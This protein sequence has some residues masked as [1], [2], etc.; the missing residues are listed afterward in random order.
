MPK[1]DRKRLTER[2]SDGPYRQ[3]QRRQP[4]S[5]LYHHPR[6]ADDWDMADRVPFLGVSLAPPMSRAE[7]RDITVDALRGRDL[8]PEYFTAAPSLLMGKARFEKLNNLCYTTSEAVLLFM[9]TETEYPRD[10]EVIKCIRNWISHVEYEYGW[11]ERVSPISLQAYG[12]NTL[13]LFDYSAPGTCF[14]MVLPLDNLVAIREELGICV[15]CGLFKPGHSPRECAVPSW[16]SMKWWNAA[17]GTRTIRL[18][19]SSIPQRVAANRKEMHWCKTCGLPT[20]FQEGY[21][22]LCEELR[23]AMRIEVAWW[24]W[25]SNLSISAQRVVE[26]A[27]DEEEQEEYEC[28]RKEQEGPEEQE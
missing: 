5:P 7:I 20:R 9:A 25:K 13:R 3:D 22:V 2:L 24:N 14:P 26:E 11:V 23:S 16:R 19:T 15:P 27:S 4:G 28:G 12:R 8:I 10:A 21:H 1:N 18:A 17:P 6:V